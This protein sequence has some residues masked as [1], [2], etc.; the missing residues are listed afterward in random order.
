[1]MN[2]REFC[3]GTVAALIAAYLPP[4]ILQDRT[5]S[6]WLENEKEVIIDCEN[7]YKFHFPKTNITNL[8]RKGDSIE[9]DFSRMDSASLDDELELYWDGC[10]QCINGEQHEHLWEEAQARAVGDYW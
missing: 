7:G 10:Q 6:R 5:V 8:K 3:K 4:S 2:R 1:M 9:F